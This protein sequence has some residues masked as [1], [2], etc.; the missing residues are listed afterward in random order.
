MWRLAVSACALALVD[1]ADWARRPIVH[2]SS[3]Q[4]EG[5]V[6]DGCHV[7][8]GVPFANAPTGPRRW[9]PPQPRASWGGVRSALLP[10]EQCPQLDILR[11][12]RFGSEDCLY[13]S[14]YQPAGCN[15]SNP[16]PVMFWIYGGAWTIGGNGEFGLYTGEHLARKHGVVVIAPNYRLDVLGWLALE[17]LR[18]ERTGQYGNYGLL[19]QRLAMRWTQDNARAFGGNPTLVTLF[20]ESAGGFSVCQHI[21]SPASDR[22]FTRAIVESGDCDG[23]WLIQDGVNAKAFG[24]TYAR[25]VG[26]PPGPGRADCLR[27]KPTTKLMEPYTSWL[28]PPGVPRR[29]DPWYAGCNGRFSKRR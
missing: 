23:P 12:M 8:R 16:C 20:G 29:H 10:A 19:D 5:R 18:D 17:E 26:C 13:L 25:L 1:G 28:C 21:T 2:T 3:G 27:A 4:V 22:L 24:D 11:G 9:R 6:V 7:F 15:S 14:V